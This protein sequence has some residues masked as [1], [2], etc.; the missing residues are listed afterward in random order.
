MLGTVT[1]LRRYPVKSMLGEDIGTSAEVTPVGLAGDRGHA[2]IHTATGR[3]VSAKNPRLWRAMLTLT[4][5]TAGNAVTITFPDGGT[6]ASADPG[7]DD[8]LSDFLGQPVTLTATPPPDARMEHADPDDVIRHGVAAAVRTELR[9]LG[10]GT[11]FNFAALHLITTST[12]ASTGADLVRYRPNIVVGTP[13]LDGYPENDWVGNDL[14]IGDVVLRVIART[15]RCAVPTLQHGTTVDV[16]T[17]ALRMVAEHNRVPAYDGGEPMPCAGVY[18][19]VTR[20]GRIGVT[21]RVRFA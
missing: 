11:F 4:A 8:R 18:A 3:V 14:V 13:D 5:R 17:S 21:D 20:P 12:L 19:Q 1:L 6:A 16:D 2:L 7:I 15:P 10:T 9:P